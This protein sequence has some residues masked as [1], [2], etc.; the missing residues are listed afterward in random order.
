MNL[1]LPTIQSSYA[2]GTA[3]FKAGASIALCS[4]ATIVGKDSTN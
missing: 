2:D 4:I 1:I 3:Q